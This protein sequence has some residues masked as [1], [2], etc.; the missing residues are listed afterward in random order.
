MG[1]TVVDGLTASN[2]AENKPKDYKNQE[3][4]NALKAYE[5]IAAKGTVQIASN[6][7]PS[8]PQAKIKEIEACIKGLNNA[9][10]ELQKGMTSVKQVATALQAVQNASAKVS[11]ELTKLSKGKGVDQSQYEGASTSASSIG[12]LAADALGRIS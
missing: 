6:L 7:M 8:V 3:L 12:S 4:D 1:A 10:T 9:I 5:A 11:V 2:W